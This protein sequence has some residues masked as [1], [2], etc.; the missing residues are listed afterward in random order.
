MSESI[1]EHYIGCCRIIKNSTLL[2]IIKTRIIK[3]QYAIILQLK[4]TQKNHR[5]P[6]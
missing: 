6:F 2:L 5:M 1:C 3:N 4:N